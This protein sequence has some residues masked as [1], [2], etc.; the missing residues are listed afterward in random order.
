MST[1]TSK[2]GGAFAAKPATTASDPGALQARIAELEQQLQSE[3]VE[4]GRVKALSERIK[5]LERE[6]AE[7]KAREFTLPDSIAN[8]ISPEVHAA[9][10]ELHRQQAT[11]GAN[12]S[13]EQAL[14][15]LDE[16]LAALEKH[17][18]ES[19]QTTKAMLQAEL[20]RR[21]DEKYPGLGNSI[22]VGGDKN[23]AWLKFLETHGPS[24]GAAWDACNFARFCEFVDLFLSQIGASQTTPE[25]TRGA[26]GVF[27]GSQPGGTPGSGAAGSGEG[28]KMTF[29]EYESAC[30]QAQ[31]DFKNGS[32]SGADYKKKIAELERMMAEGLVTFE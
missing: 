30:E 17:Q 14:S 11:A 19:Q 12:G 15:P 23:V 27:P 9:L 1:Q 3:R 29:S 7:A 24:V 31:S 21:L 20:E 16:R 26:G 10:K 8:A 28:D 32:L 2:F 13:G 25:R 5:E 6:N 4:K 18:A 22:A